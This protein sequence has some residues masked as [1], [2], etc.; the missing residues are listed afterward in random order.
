MAGLSADVMRSLTDRGCCAI[1][2]AVA[3]TLSEGS[4]VVK[5]GCGSPK[6]RWLRL[7]RIAMVLL[8]AGGGCAGVV[9]L[10]M[11]LAC[12][13]VTSKQR[14]ALEEW[15]PV[16]VATV[17]HGVLLS[18]EVSSRRRILVGASS[19]VFCLLYQRDVLGEYRSHMGSG[20]SPRWRSFGMF[21]CAVTFQQDGTVIGVQ[22]PCW[23]VVGA[24]FAYPI[25]ALVGAR[26]RHRHRRRDGL[27]MRC[28]YDLR[29][30]ESGVCS[31]CGAG[32]SG[33]GE[34]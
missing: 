4:F 14:S 30:N 18:L 11:A 32:V 28:G 17:D 13:P 8:V 6:R 26:A 33:F 20:C 29:G 19:R 34:G 23:F 9:W 24:L 5:R 22:V 3:G 16:Q 2:V 31:E 15:L 25:L 27:C 1:E 12:H 10:Y 7:R 21:A